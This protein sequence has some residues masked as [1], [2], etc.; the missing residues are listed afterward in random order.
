MNLLRFIRPE[1]SSLPQVSASMAGVK[2]FGGAI[3]V[4]FFLGFVEAPFC[5]LANRPF[6]YIGLIP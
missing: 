6:Y 4:R 2:S 5:K 1:L 3:T